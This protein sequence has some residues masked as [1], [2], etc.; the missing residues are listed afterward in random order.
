MRGQ[1]LYLRLYEAL[2]QLSWDKV[3]QALNEAVRPQTAQDQE[4]LEWVQPCVPLLGQRLSV[5]KHTSIHTLLDR[6]RQLL[7]NIHGGEKCMHVLTKKL[8]VRACE[9]ECCQKS[10]WSPADV[11]WSSLPVCWSCPEHWGSGCPA[12]R[13]PT[14][15]SLRGWTSP[16]QASPQIV[17]SATHPDK[18]IQC[19]WLSSIYICIEF[20][21]KIYKTSKVP[22]PCCS[23]CQFCS[24]SS[25]CE[26]TRGRRT[27]VCASQTNCG[28]HCCTGWTWRSH[29]CWWF[30]PSRSLSRMAEERYIFRSGFSVMN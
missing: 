13:A 24:C 10:S 18:F 8:E 9:A 1:D 20:L 3:L 16:G 11:W 5:G 30:S 15:S 19:T 2:S 25:W 17:G 22:L 7:H 23:P 21:Q 4:L 6:L 27:W 28:T 14:A 26:C 12:R 29:W